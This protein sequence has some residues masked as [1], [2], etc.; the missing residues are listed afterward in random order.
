M[1]S[2][3]RQATLDKVLGGGYIDM[4]YTR[5]ESGSNVVHAIQYTGM[6]PEVH[7]VC[8]PFL[9]D[10]FVMD[11]A[12]AFI[13]KNTDWCSKSFSLADI[14]TLPHAV[15]MNPMNIDRSPFTLIKLQFVGCYLKQTS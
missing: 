1:Q 15:E 7:L 2:E 6:I 9:Q 10:L 13:W 8:K 14:D 5:V 3:I 12:V 11:E 4:T